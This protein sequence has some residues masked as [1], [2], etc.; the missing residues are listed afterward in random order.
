MA[1]ENQK[2]QSAWQMNAGRMFY[3]L[4]GLFK[5]SGSAAYWEERYLKG[6]NSGS[7]SY[8]RLAEFKAEIINRFVAD[9]DLRSVIE[10]GC[11]DGHQLSLAHYPQYTGLDVSAAA[12]AQCGQFYAG[13]PSKSFF[14]YSTNAFFDRAGVLKADLALSLDVIFHLVEEEV[15]QAYMRHLFAAAR[16]FVIV[17]SSDYDGP[18]QIHERH[19]KF[20]AW[21]ESNCPNWQIQEVIRN[22]YPYDTADPAET[23]QADF[24]I[25]GVKSS[26]D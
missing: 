2:K 3:R 16:R 23:S 4:K 10:F 26:A 19:H 20:T 17:Y 21:V 5:F 14:L 18:Q 1:S 12:I 8:G 15:Y 13:D 25:Y 6:G 7:G 9:H 22:P 24:Y 11:G